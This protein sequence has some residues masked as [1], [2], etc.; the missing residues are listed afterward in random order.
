MNRDPRFPAG[1]VPIAKE[2]LLF[3]AKV[4]SGV[5]LRLRGKSSN[6]AGGYG[7]YPL[8]L[9]GGAAVAVALFLPATAWL[10]HH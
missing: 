6:H 8:G 7:G 5:H 3:V 10:R 2:P 9:W 4:V 1:H